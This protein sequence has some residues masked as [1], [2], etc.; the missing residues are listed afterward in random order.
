MKKFLKLFA[1]AMKI[2]S[3]AITIVKFILSLS[4]S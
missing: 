3:S 2:M 1:E 4:L